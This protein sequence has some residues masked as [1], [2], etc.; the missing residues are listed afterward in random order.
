MPTLLGAIIRDCNKSKY[1]P[2][3]VNAKIRIIRNSIAHSHSQI[4]LKLETVTSINLKPNGD[5]EET[6]AMNWED[7]ENFCLYY[8]FECRAL[9]TILKKHRRLVL[10][11]LN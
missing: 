10:E 6:E 4:D 8:F 9:R 3:V 7:F 11:S 5:K 2:Y 1:F